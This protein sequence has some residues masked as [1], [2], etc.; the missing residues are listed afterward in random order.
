MEV[1]GGGCRCAQA[2]QVLKAAKETVAVA[3]Q[4]PVKRRYKSGQ[5]QDSAIVIETAALANTWGVGYAR[6]D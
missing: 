6:I 3:M 5:M 4:L 1:R 2:R